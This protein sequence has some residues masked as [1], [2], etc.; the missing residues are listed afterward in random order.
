MDKVSYAACDACGQDDRAPTGKQME[1]ILKAEDAPVGWHSRG[2]LPHFDGGS[3]CQFITL[4][5]GDALPREVIEKWKLELSREK[6]EKAKILFYKRIEDYLD[7]GC[8]ECYL[9]NEAIA[10]Q[11]QASLPYFDAVRYKLIAWV[12]MPNHIHF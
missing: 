7:K 2:Y 1:K 6:D 3:I 10:E 5:L 8:G 9:Q 11:I 4:H 12:I